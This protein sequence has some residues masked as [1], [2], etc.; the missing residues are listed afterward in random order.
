M[1]PGVFR[2]RD[3]VA[4]PAGAPVRA[5]PPPSPGPRQPAVPRVGMRKTGLA[6]SANSAL[7]E[8]SHPALDSPLLRRA[9]PLEITLADIV[10]RLRQGRFSNE[11]S[12]SQT[13]LLGGRQE[14]GGKS[15]LQEGR[16]D[17]E[18]LQWFL[19]VLCNL[20]VKTPA[21]NA[22]VGRPTMQRTQRAL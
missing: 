12:V 19:C 5:Q 2:R 1:V 18:G 3:G 11:Q 9:M 13:I 10:A 20:P 8:Q 4:P 14:L 17:R 7:A 15:N 16:E 22:M 21:R 6:P